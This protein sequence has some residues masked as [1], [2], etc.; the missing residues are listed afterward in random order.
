MA[1]TLLSS[2]GRNPG[3]PGSPD[4]SQYNSSIE[5]LNP[6]SFLAAFSNLETHEISDSEDSNNP[7]PPWWDGIYGTKAGNVGDMEEELLDACEDGDLE[8]VRELVGN[9]DY[10]KSNVNLDCRVPLGAPNAPQYSR[11]KRS[12][13]YRPS[14][15]QIAC[16]NGRM[17][18]IEFLIDREEVRFFCHPIIL[19][20]YSSTHLIAHQCKFDTTDM[21][22]K[23]ALHDATIEG[24]LD[25]VKILL[26]TQR[27]PNM[28]P[29]VDC[30]RNTVLHHACDNEHFEIAKFLVTQT[31]R[32]KIDYRA[33]NE[34]GDTALKIACG[35]GCFDIVK[36]IVE[37]GK[38]G[39]EDCE[40]PDKK[41]TRPLHAACWKGHFKVVEYLVGVMG[42]EIDS[43]DAQ[44]RTGLYLAAVNGHLE[45]VKYL[46]G[47]GA[48]LTISYAFSFTPQEVALK[49]GWKEIGKF[50]RDLQ[51]QKNLE[52]K[53]RLEEAN[54]RTAG[55]DAKEKHRRLLKAGEMVQV[56]KFV[57]GRTD[58][59][60]KE[61][62]SFDF[63]EI[64]G[65][66]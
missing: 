35:R 16:A 50:L 9:E 18:I 27:V 12:V 29:T 62:D 41:N 31:F 65:G 60:V 19:L 58:K 38:L 17:E 52:K 21:D 24:H 48:D 39:L 49:N 8:A 59:N 54:A 6:S 20:I 44:N 10:Q 26:K 64:E 3:S 25:V 43:F 22:E 46:A 45:C 56:R 15:F 4:S 42:V 32:K 37:R 63:E 1:L 57:K 33:V 5:A 30:K 36:V 11:T 14:A 55:V 47:L 23:N 2:P 66:G 28:V 40:F 13:I 61:L 51:R 53:Q 7:D 34:K